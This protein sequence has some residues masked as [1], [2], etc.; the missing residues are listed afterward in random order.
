[1]TWKRWLLFGLAC[2]VLFA[3]VT[4][5]TKIA[6]TA[7]FGP[8][9]ADSIVPIDLVCTPQHDIM[10]EDLGRPEREQEAMGCR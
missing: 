8:Y 6:L 4:L 1:L 3:L 2:A 7:I 10:P 9:E 5:G